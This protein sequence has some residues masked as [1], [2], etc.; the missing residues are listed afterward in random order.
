MCGIVG[1][2]GPDE[3]AKEA[4]MG[5]FT[6]QHRGQDAAGILSYD[7]SAEGP[8]FHL[9]KDNG[10]VDRVFN[11][12]IIE[13]LK[14]TFALGHTRYSTVGRSD[15]KLDI[16][17]LVL[18][19]PYGIGMAHN[20]NVVNYYE[21]V[22]KLR[23]EKHRIAL[24]SN[25]L[26]VIENIFAE[27]LL[28]VV[29]AKPLTDNQLTLDHLCEAISTVY[30]QAI[31]GFSVVS[32]IAGQG[33]FAFRDPKGI[34]PLILGNKTLEDGR[35]AYCLASESIVLQFLGYDI[36]R[37]VM[38][39]EVVFIDNQQNLHTK[40]V[41]T[42]ATP[43]HCM[44]EWVYFA[45]AESVLE[46]SGVYGS[47]LNL[48]VGLA[49]LIQQKIDA[50]EMTPDVIVPVPETARIASIAMA[51]EL[52]I[53]YREVIIKN[54]YIHRS[55][56]LNTQ[57]KR[58]KAVDLKLNPVIGEIKG[59]NILLVDDSIVRGTTSRRLISL[60]RKAGAK[61]VYFAS[62]CSPIR[63][64]C[65]YGIDFPTKSELLATKRT[66]QEIAEQLGADKV[67]YLDQES[68]RQAIGI[69]NM[70][71]ACLDENYPTDISSA[72]AFRSKRKTQ[73]GCG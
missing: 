2:A 69:K 10:L 52:K 30:E 62:T 33:M 16:Q 56:I 11:E 46:G 21:L 64:P 19:F 12:S 44:L 3:A 22:N 8:G 71:M 68:M 34:R 72:A 66:E 5:L 7:P 14:G 17:P 38:P 63:S 54:R 9:W 26:E 1:I 73:R 24:T 28:D 55:F 25:D 50:G 32:L 20:G 29:E 15:D 59:K 37:D 65:Y 27:A 48:G 4:F 49:K 51:E 41:I 61:E 43:A 18:N 6:M 57:E 42:N 31:G 40:Q 67:I 36:V 53:P 58:A 47:R 35:K 13:K 39:G 70:C 23:T 45:G 60:A